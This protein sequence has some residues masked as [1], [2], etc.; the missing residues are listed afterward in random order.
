MIGEA[1]QVLGMT[2]SS[3]MR[4]LA[5]DGARKLTGDIPRQIAG[6]VGKL[7]EHLGKCES[8]L[9]RRKA[10]LA[11]AENERESYAESL[12]ELQR[13]AAIEDNIE[14]IDAWVL[15]RRR[16]SGLSAPEQGENAAPAMRRTSRGAVGDE[17]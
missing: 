3:W 6:E 4:Y 1:V 2:V 8:R 16:L 11:E 15:L 7:E 9:R 14:Q 17:S 5:V 13:V 12:G 10:E